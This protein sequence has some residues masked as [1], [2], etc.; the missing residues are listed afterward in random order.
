M[1]PRLDLG[2]EIGSWRIRYNLI[3]KFGLSIDQ[4]Q[5]LN[6]KDGLFLVLDSE[7]RNI[8]H[9]VRYQR[10][11]EPFKKKLWWYKAFD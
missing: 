1:W 8:L 4:I 3:Q 5:L 2:V 11:E 9:D 10:F 6:P 7:C